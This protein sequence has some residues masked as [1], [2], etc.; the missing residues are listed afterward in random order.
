[1]STFLFYELIRLNN[2][3]IK[4]EDFDNEFMS[5]PDYPSLSAVKDTLDKFDIENIIAEFNNS[6]FNKLPNT[7]ISSL[8]ENSE[9]ILVKKKESIVLIT[10]NFQHKKEIDIS[11]FLENWSGLV[12]AVEKQKSTS[13]INIDIDNIIKKSF[14]IV[15]TLILYFFYLNFDRYEFLYAFISLIGLCYCIEIYKTQH[16]INSKFIDKI[17]SSKKENSCQ[18]V[19]QEDRINIFGLKLSDMALLYFLTTTIFSLFLNKTQF[20]IILLSSLSIISVIYSIYIQFFKIRKTCKIC[21]I[22]IGII[23]SN[24][25]ICFLHFE[26]R[27]STRVFLLCLIYFFI[28]TPLYIYVNKIININKKLNHDNLINT[29]FKRNYDIFKRELFSSKQVNFKYKDLFFIGKK[30]SKIHITLILNLE[31]FFCKEAFYIL[32]DIYLSNREYISLQIRFN[33]FNKPKLPEIGNFIK[34]LI[35]AYNKGENEFF[36]TFDKW[37]I[38]K[39][40]FSKEE[41]LINDFMEIEDISKENIS[42][43]LNDSPMLLINGYL[44]SQKYQIE[45]IYYFIEEI[46]KEYY[47]N[48]K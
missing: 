33:F 6:H 15:I 39:Y 24:S 16:E 31:C 32:K 44:F 13:K 17:C 1:M 23:L 46:I 22:L 36:S 7:F 2:Y 5:H 42:E 20:I 40:H 25:L 19:M 41:S 12:I 8:K 14:I 37:Y 29:R 45:D 18:M 38:Q 47:N 30:E 10:N 4:K 48:D 35:Y 43:K 9:L 28:I 21:L 27:F 11:I 3:Q 34:H 26:F